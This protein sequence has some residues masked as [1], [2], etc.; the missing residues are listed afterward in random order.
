MTATHPNGQAQRKSLAD[1]IERFDA[2]LDGLADNL[3]EAVATAVQQAVSQAVRAAVA[4]AVTELLNNAAL[5]RTLQGQAETVPA[6]S[7]SAVQKGLWTGSLRQTWCILRGQLRQVATAAPAHIG[8]AHA[9]LANQLQRASATLRAQRDT[10]MS[11]GRSL[12]QALPSLLL[13][14]GQLRK[15]SNSLSKAASP[16][17]DIVRNTSHSIAGMAIS[18]PGRSPPPLPPGSNSTPPPA[19]SPSHA[20]T[21]G[22]P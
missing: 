10:I 15:P 9:R 1:Q 5:L 21:A 17:T 20:P 2:I 22:T 8:K 18:I 13:R 7:P 12:W 11:C 6:P 3:H 14:L 19:P 4:A 16:G